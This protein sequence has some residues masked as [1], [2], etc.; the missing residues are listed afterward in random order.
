MFRDITS[1]DMQACDF[2]WYLPV[3]IGENLKNSWSLTCLSLFLMTVWSLIAKEN[4]IIL[5]AHCIVLV[6]IIHQKYRLNFVVLTGKTKGNKF[7]I[8]AVTK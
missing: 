7:L 5:F 3:K 4:I 8:K 2:C 6:V 1:I